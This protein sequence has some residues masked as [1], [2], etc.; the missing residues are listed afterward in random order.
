MTTTSAIVVWTTAKDG[1]SEVTY[2]TGASPPS[3][4]AAT[5]TLFTEPAIGGQQER[6]YYVHVAQLT[7]LQPG[8]SYSYTISTGGTLLA[9][10]VS[11]RTD[12][13]PQD[14]TLSFAVVGD[15]G[16]LG[17]N[18]T[19]IRDA[20]LGR[21]YEMVLHTGDLAYTHGTYS[22]LDQS[23]F[24]PYGQ[25]MR[26]VPFYPAMGNHDYETLN[27]QPYRDVFYLP[28]NAPAQHRESYYSFDYGPVHFVSLDTEILGGYRGGLAEASDQLAWL[29]N[30]LASTSQPWK[31]VF[32]HR[33]SYPSSNI[34]VY[35]NPIAVTPI[36][37]QRGVDIVFSGHDHL[38]ART[39]PMI[40][41]APE[42][43]GNGG[44]IYPTTGGGGGGKHLCEP[45]PYTAICLR[46]YHFLHVTVE[47]DCVLSYDAI[48]FSSGVIDHFELNRC[49]PDSDSDG[50]LDGEEVAAGS[51]PLDPASTPLPTA[52]PTPT[53]SGATGDAN[54]DATVSSIDAA[55][56]LQ[57]SAGLLPAVPCELLADVNSDG[58]VTAIDAALILQYVAGLLSHL[59]L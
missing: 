4:A 38:Y 8:T 41:G 29:D 39:L 10:N 49:D 17:P 52:T 35:P 37:Q 58:E 16:T 11:F 55:L 3:T 33:P 20:M 24:P 5:S 45:R 40:D 19:G 18:Q 44:V 30:D 32:L 57:W 14:T 46:M 23:F 12:S 2:N 47:N 22:E 6:S 1:L 50:F 31:V 59:P 28:E 48:T 51:D 34:P 15:S 7:G 25:I 43:I 56:L 21:D 27:G 53:P 36:L 26:R 54:C 13:G 42:L 9:P